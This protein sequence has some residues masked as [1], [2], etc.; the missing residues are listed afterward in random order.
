MASAK[1]AAKSIGTKIF[2]AASGFRPIDSMA[3]DPMNPMANPGPID[4]IPMAKALANMTD[5]ILVL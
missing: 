3:L 4:P 5:S 1:A 2:P